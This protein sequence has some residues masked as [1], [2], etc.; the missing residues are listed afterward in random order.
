MDKWLYIAYKSYLLIVKRHFE[1]SEE[2]PVF[3][4][5]VHYQVQIFDFSFKTKLAKIYAFI[6]KNACRR[7]VVHHGTC[8][9]HPLLKVCFCWF[10]LEI[11]S[12]GKG[13]S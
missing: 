8:R 7:F 11:R 12:S 13:V 2:I 1:M 6:K 3:M 9:I 4:F 10:S 5:I